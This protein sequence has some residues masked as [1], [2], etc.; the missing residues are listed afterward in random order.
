MQRAVVSLGTRWE[1]T[2]DEMAVLLGGVSVRTYAR[3]K[4]GQLGRAGI[5]TAARMSNLMGIHKALRLLFKDAARGY[6]WIKRENTTF[7]GKTALDVMLGGQLTD[8]MRVRSYLDTVRGA[9]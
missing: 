3:W 5:D 8:L 2:D 7:G 4:V 6:G 9:W 1:L